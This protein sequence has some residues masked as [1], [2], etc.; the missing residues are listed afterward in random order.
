MFGDYAGA[1]YTCGG[2]SLIAGFFMFF[3]PRWSTK[4]KEDSD[5]KLRRFLS[6]K[7]TGSHS[8]LLQILFGCLWKK[9][10]PESKTLSNVQYSVILTTEGNENV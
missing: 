2:I 6:R 4:G 8:Q 7:N 1:F 3:V 9:E 5:L 10:L